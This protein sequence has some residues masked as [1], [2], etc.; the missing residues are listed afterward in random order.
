MTPLDWVLLAVIAVSAGSGFRRGFVVTSLTL[1]GAAVGGAIGFLLGTALTTSTTSAAPGLLSLLGAM[2]GAGLLGRA[3]G[4]LRT[5]WM[6][7]GSRAGAGRPARLLRTVPVSVDRVLGAIVSAVV[8]CLIAWL[9]AG[10]VRRED[11]PPAATQAVRESLVLDRLR[12]VLPTSAPLLDRLDAWD[13][14]PALLPSRAEPRVPRGIA[15]DPDVRAA[16]ASVVRVVGTACARRS[17]GSGWVAAPGLVV[18]SAHVVAGQRTTQVQVGG[19]GR[20]L[21]AV[22]VAFDS[23]ND[24]AVLRVDGLDAPALVLSADVAAGTPVALLG[25]PGNGDY[26]VRAGRLG[27]ERRIFARSEPGGRVVARAV[28]RFDSI[29]RPGNSGGPLVDRDGRI[30][31]TVFAA[32]AE[33]GSRQGFAVPNDPVRRALDGGGAP[34]GTGACADGAPRIGGP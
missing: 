16:A 30:V 34:V 21:K 6:R 27:A 5:R 8:V 24:I 18:T 23:R 19:R 22:A 32:S 10:I 11:A 33:R 2:L 20:R 29:V 14:L 25:F 13:P 26:R 9:A 4:R 31:A 3:A 28:R 1:V 7:S 12:S 15:R 17:S